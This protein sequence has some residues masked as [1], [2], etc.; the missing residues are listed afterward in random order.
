MRI[1]QALSVALTLTGCNAIFGLDP[2]A[3]SIDASSN[4]ADAAPP[5]ADPLADD[6]DD[7]VANGVDNCPTIA[8]PDQLN[9]EAPEQ[10]DGFG[11]I[12][13]LC[14][15]RFDLAQHDEDG[16]EVGDGC[17]SCPHV[18]NP[19]QEDELEPA[20]QLDGVG[21]AC[22][23]NPTLGGDYL[24]FFDGFGGS[25]RA[26][27]WQ[28]VTGDDTL[29]VAQDSL[30]L[31]APLE[32]P[33]I[34]VVE[35]N[36]PDLLVEAAIRVISFEP[37]WPPIIGVIAQFD[38]AQGEGRAC[39]LDD[40]ESANARWARGAVY[41]DG[42]LGLGGEVSASGPFD[43]GPTYTLR[44][45]VGA[46]SAHT[47]RARSNAFISDAYLQGLP[48]PAFTLLG[49]LGI[50]LQGTAARIPYVIAWGRGTSD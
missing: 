23:P 9:S 43:P 49:G 38:Q 1:A 45:L 31:A 48:K 21:D 30:V 13:D 4:A 47:C 8:N 10:L 40:E 3:I 5:D 35:A 20:G 41:S 22:D 39:V 2:T 26:A 42:A 16:D 27:A 29:V 44:I 15:A 24:V 19:G 14:P 17:D 25:E 50:Y 18:D 7:G 28:I 37:S 11:D 36:A 32:K 12:C 33:L 46:S 6:D 34:V